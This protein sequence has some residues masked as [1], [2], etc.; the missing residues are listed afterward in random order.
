MAELMTDEYVKSF[1]TITAVE[2]LGSTGEDVVDEFRVGWK[3][4]GWTVGSIS[5]DPESAWVHVFDED[6]GIRAS[7]PSARALLTWEPGEREEEGD[8]K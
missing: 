7:V 3:G 8:D 2:V 5:L 6:N 4:Y 1:P